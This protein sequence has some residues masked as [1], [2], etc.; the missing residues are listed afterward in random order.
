MAVDEVLALPSTTS[1]T[2]NVASTLLNSKAEDENTA[3]A[4]TEHDRPAVRP[5]QLAAIFDTEHSHAMMP[6]KEMFERV[7]GLFVGERKPM[8]A[9]VGA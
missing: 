1:H 5:E 3:M 9:E 7:L 2:L 4:G 6:V 8:V